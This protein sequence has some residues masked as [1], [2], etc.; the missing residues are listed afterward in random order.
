[1]LS[2][3]IQGSSR[4][5]GLFLCLGCGPGNG[6][7]TTGGSESGS[8]T[9]GSET[10]ITG[11]GD[12]ACGLVNCPSDNPCQ[13]VDCCA[14]NDPGCEPIYHDTQIVLA[15]SEFSSDCTTG[16]HGSDMPTSGLSLM[17]ADD[18]WCALVDKPSSGPSP[19]NLV[20][21]GEPLRSYLWHKV[22]ASHECPGVD[23]DG[24]AMPPPPNHCPLTIQD[25]AL[26]AVIT[27]WICCGA[28]KAPDDPLGEGCF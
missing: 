23:G 24:K 25:P 7:P 22:N 28:P 15:W 19:L 10:D 4:G 27:Q 6:D 3:S 12:D 9:G 26:M 17:A 1:M 16:C 8:G 20:E 21:P 18:P 14:P 13:T 5:L 11:D 2:R